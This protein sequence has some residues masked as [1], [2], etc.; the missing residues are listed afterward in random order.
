MF[1]FISFHMVNINVPVGVSATLLDTQHYHHTHDTMGYAVT[2]LTGT[3]FQ[4][5]LMD[6]SPPDDWLYDRVMLQLLGT[7]GT[8]GVD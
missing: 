5:L 6:R 4:V 7:A 1:N 3:V 2:K 8:V